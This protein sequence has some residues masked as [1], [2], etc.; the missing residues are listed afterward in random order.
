MPRGSAPGER[1][2]GRSAGTS[3]R[4]KVAFEI[5]DLAREHG[6]A[7]IAKLAELAGLT[8]G[9]PAEAEAVRVTA[10]RELLDRGFGKPTQPLSGDPDG[11]P[12]AID[13]RWADATPL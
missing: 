10:I 2:G 13:F 12:M 8:P 7:G 11:A 6:P 3:G 5:R 1:R 9:T 4:P